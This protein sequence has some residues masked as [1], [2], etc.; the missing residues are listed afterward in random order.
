ML[1]DSYKLL[2]R[3]QLNRLR[4]ELVSS[5]REAFAAAEADLRLWMPSAAKE[6]ES[7]AE[8]IERC[9]E[10]FDAGR[11]FA[12][13]MVAPAGGVV[14][15]LNLTPEPDHAVVGYWVRPEWR[16]IG[17]TALALRVLTD[18]AFASIPE[19]QRIHAHLDAAN[20]SSRRVLQKAGFHHKDTF[21]RPGRTLAES[22]TEWLYVRDRYPRGTTTDRLVL[23]D[24]GIA[25]QEAA[26]RL[27]TDPT[28]PRFMDDF[29]PRTPAE[30]EGWIADVAE[31]TRAEPWFRSW[32][33]ELKDSG[34]VV[35]WLGFGP[36]RRGIGDID[37]AYV[38]DVRHRGHG[39]ASEALRGAINYCFTTLGAESFWGQCHTDNEASARAMRAA[40][41]EFLATVDGE[42]R[43]SLA[44]G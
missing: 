6:Q 35:G 4:P 34:E 24:L 20:A 37:F 3:A 12:Y 42:H 8:F 14:G 41:L 30:V 18:A 15:Y 44:R 32:A 36:D 25:D 13:G 28:V 38:V 11:T 23:R 33:M 40:G 5:F 26:V 1:G 19:V 10:A 31:A 9:V 22:D 17:L 16:G 7:A 2:G 27:W 39:Y 21:T 29:G 43:F